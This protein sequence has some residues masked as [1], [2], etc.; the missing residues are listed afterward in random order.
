RRISRTGPIGPIEREQAGE[1]AAWRHYEDAPKTVRAA[2]ACGS[3][4]VAI[5]RLHERTWV[6]AI[7][8]VEQ[9]QRGER[10]VGGYFEDCAVAAASSSRVIDKARAAFARGAIQIAIAPLG[11]GV[12]NRAIGPVERG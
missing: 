6:P 8:R 9:G 11:Q 3:I 5:T 2:A 12:K 4:E 1:R 7:G 10:V